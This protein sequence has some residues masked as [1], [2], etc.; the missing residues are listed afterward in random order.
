MAEII[1]LATILSPIAL[2]VWLTLAR[3]KAQ[4]RVA[5]MYQ[6]EDERPAFDTVE[7][8]EVGPDGLIAGRRHFAPGTL[9]EPDSSG[10]EYDAIRALQGRR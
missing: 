9:E 2:M 10:G 1:F 7:E 3:R 4:A 5:E 8:L 6:D